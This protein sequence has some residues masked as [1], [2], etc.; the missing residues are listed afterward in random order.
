MESKI[1]PTKHDAGKPRVDLFPPQAILAISEVLGYGAKKYSDHNWQNNGGMEYSRL[2]AA[3]QRHMLAFWDGEQS[4][5]ETG[6]SH[7]AHAAC[8]IVF[9]LSYEIEENGIDDRRD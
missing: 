3:A 2:Y 5:G 8:C 9:L 7:L 4:D 1:A 6:M